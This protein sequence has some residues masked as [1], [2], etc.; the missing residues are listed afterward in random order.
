MYWKSSLTFLVFVFA[1]GCGQKAQD[2]EESIQKVDGT[3]YYTS[4]Y[5]IEAED[6]VSILDKPEVKIIDFRRNSAY[7]AEHIDGAI[8]I[9]RSDIEDPTYPFAGMK[10]EKQQIAALLGSK[11]IAP[12]DVLIVYDD[13]G[14]ADAARFWWVLQN[15]GF[16]RVQILNG[17]LA[18]WKKVGGEVNNLPPEVKK[19]EFRFSNE[20]SEGLVI[21]KEELLEKLE[22]EQDLLLLD[23]RSLDEYSGK[24]RKNGALKAGRITGSTHIDWQV[25]VDLNNDMKFKSHDELLVQYGELEGFRE[26]LVV[27]YCHTGVRSAHTLFVLTQLLGFENVRNY[28][29]SWTE[30]SFDS[31]LP[32]SQDSVTTIVE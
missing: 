30:W 29:G 12:S 5:L 17:G 16:D 15:H 13:R 3:G 31:D 32:F 27:T 2:V 19:A 1:L 25:A 24:R 14:S 7:A 26:K 4:E 22:S 11:G 8:N 28:D 23:T 20:V 10:A 6:L 18:A 9:W 21:S